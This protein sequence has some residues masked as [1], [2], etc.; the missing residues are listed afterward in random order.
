MTH[1]G[2]GEGART[3]QT[4]RYLGL[5]VVALGCLPG[6]GTVGSLHTDSRGIG[7]SGDGSGREWSPRYVSFPRSKDGGPCWHGHPLAVTEYSLSTPFV[8]P[9]SFPFSVSHSFKHQLNLLP[10]VGTQLN[11]LLGLISHQSVTEHVGQLNPNNVPENIV[12]Y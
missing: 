9:H 7:S 6:M 12:G 2:N 1:P 8:H 11:V 10:M 5:P 3:P 4:P